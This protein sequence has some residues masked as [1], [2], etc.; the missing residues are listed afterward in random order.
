LIDKMAA[1]NDLTGFAHKFN[2]VVPPEQRGKH[3]SLAAA[4]AAQ[5]SASIALDGVAPPKGAGSRPT[6]TPEAR[7]T[8][9][10]PETE[11]GK[12]R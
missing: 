12:E 3:P 6:I 1:Q 4:R 5:A 11:S 10:G 2:S 9:Q 7:Q 8:T